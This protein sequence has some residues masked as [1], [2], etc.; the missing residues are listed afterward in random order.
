MIWIAHRTDGFWESDAFLPW[1]VWPIVV[2]FF[3]LFGSMTDRWRRYTATKRGSRGNPL[4][5]SARY[6]LSSTGS[7]SVHLARNISPDP[8]SSSSTAFVPPPPIHHPF[9][10]SIPD[11]VAVFY[12]SLSYSSSRSRSRRCTPS[13][14]NCTSSYVSGAV[15]HTIKRVS[16]S[17]VTSTLVQRRTAEV[18]TSS[19]YFTPRL[20]TN[21]RADRPP[22]DTIHL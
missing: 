13:Y 4:P 6:Y 18:V 20:A 9:H 1:R 21:H 17:Y 11:S 7:S 15:S 19:V 22:H 14:T 8:I 5:C 16:W 12:P 10:T 3:V 2:S